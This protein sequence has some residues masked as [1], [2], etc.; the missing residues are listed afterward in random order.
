MRSDRE[1]QSSYYSQRRRSRS[2][3]RRPRSRSR[4]GCTRDKCHSNRCRAPS[5]R[6]RSRCARDKCYSKRSR[7]PSPHWSRDNRPSGSG[8]SSS[9]IKIDRT[10]TP[11][12]EEVPLVLDQLNEPEFSELF[13][14]H[15][16]QAW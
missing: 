8:T 16:P 10:S 11:P 1:R 12:R 5:P 7:T 14:T 15:E 13:G 2:R 4:S 9:V 3:S 6:S